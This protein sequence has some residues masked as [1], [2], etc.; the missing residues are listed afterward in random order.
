MFRKYLI[1]STL[2][3]FL[4]ANGKVHSFLSESEEGTII[5]QVQ[6][7]I[8]S[9]MNELLEK[10]EILKVY[11][12]NH[13]EIRDPRT[14]NLH[15]IVFIRK[16][17]IR[18]FPL[19]SGKFEFKGLRLDRK[20]LFE[21]NKFK[22]I[23]LKSVSLNVRIRESD[24]NRVLIVK[25]YNSKIQDPKVLLKPD[26]IILSGQCDWWIIKTNFEASGSFQIV[27][28]RYIE[29]VPK[30][31]KVSNIDIPKFMVRKI[32]KKINPVLDIKVLP[33]ELELHTVKISENE[34]ILSSH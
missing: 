11:I 10:P 30:T 2:L 32:I 4:F 14:L 1:L 22:V 18:N 8:S 3:I 27:D 9:V 13:P 26:K 33:F 23:G 20:V 19:Y 16:G 34:L 5:S 29:F 7:K 28:N 21:E 17:I 6:E 15:L 24:L 12:L 25:A 31:I